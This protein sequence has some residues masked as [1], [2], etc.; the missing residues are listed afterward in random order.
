MGLY[1]EEFEVGQVYTTGRRLV[2]REM[3]AQ[4]GALTG[5]NNPLHMDL[6]RMRESPHGDVIGHIVRIDRRG[7][8][9]VDAT[10]GQGAPGRP[11]TVLARFRLGGG[12]LVSTEVWRAS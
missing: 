10:I 2:Q 11:F 9:E 5:D 3:I 1:F 7:K 4:F 6:E 8:V 12:R